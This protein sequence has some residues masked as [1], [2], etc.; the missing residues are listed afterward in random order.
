MDNKENQDSDLSR[1]LKILIMLARSVFNDVEKNCENSK[2]RRE[3]CTLNTSRIV[4]WFEKKPRFIP[5]LIE[6]KR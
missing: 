2:S 5:F 1:H 3:K 6:L 4:I